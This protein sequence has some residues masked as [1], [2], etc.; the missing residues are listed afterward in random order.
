VR[1]HVAVQPAIV[2]ANIPVTVTLLSAKT[3]QPLCAAILSTNLGSAPSTVPSNPSSNPST[4]SGSTPSHTSHPV[5][6]KPV[7]HPTTPTTPQGTVASSATSTIVPGTTNGMHNP[8]KGLCSSET[9]AYRLWLVLLVLYALIV[10]GLLWLEF[11]M[12]WSWAQ[13]PERVA[14]AIL[15][16]LILLLGLLAAF[17][18][19]P[20]MTQLLLIENSNL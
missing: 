15:V 18:N 3:G 17:W 6:S 19:H 20:R 4:T 13:T 1:I 10:G 11:P 9:G 14:T 7:T 5:V 8:V 16:I 12:S 2:S